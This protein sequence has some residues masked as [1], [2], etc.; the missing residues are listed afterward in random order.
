MSSYTALQNADE[1]AT[2]LDQAADEISAVMPLAQHL[3]DDLTDAARR[4]RELHDQH[5]EVVMRNVR[6]H[7]DIAHTQERVRRRDDYMAEHATTTPTH[8]Q[9]AIDL[10]TSTNTCVP[11]HRAALTVQSYITWLQAEHDGLR[12]L[13]DPKGPH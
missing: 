8:V 9:Q 7:A 10:L 3:V 6:L 13:L 1:I 11:S 4:L 2:R 12:M 5:G